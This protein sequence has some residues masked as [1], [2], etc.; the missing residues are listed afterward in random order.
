MKTTILPELS[1]LPEAVDQLYDVFT[2]CTVEEHG[3]SSY[4]APANNIRPFKDGVWLKNKIQSAFDTLKS[5][6]GI[7]SAN[8]DIS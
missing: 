7:S 4:I 1:F 6:S 2:F 3:N 5:L 8:E